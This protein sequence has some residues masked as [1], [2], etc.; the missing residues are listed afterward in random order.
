MYSKEVKV[1]TYQIKAKWS[2]ELIQDLN[3][4][5]G[6]DVE[7]ELEE[8][9]NRELDPTYAAHKKRE[10]SEKKLKRIFKDEQIN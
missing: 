9:L 6:I 7:S 5:H 1:G 3:S 8:L 10:E 4:Y 2:R